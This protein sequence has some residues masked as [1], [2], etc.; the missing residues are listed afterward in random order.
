ME[1]AVPAGVKF[2]RVVV[3]KLDRASSGCGFIGRDLDGI[4][5]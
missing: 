4:S 3:R 1:S 2:N 5:K